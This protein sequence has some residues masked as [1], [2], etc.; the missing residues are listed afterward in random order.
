MQFLKG[1]IN[2]CIAKNITVLHII[3]KNNTRFDPETGIACFSP[4]QWHEKLEEHK[5][6]L[7][8]EFDSYQSCN[9]LFVII[10]GTL[11]GYPVLN[12]LCT[13]QAQSLL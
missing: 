13:C 4:K 5:I 11:M 1:F 6:F 7:N 9:F 10:S 8:T 12:P 3:T 2:F